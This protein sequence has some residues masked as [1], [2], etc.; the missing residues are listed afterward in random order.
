MTVSEYLKGKG[1]YT[2]GEDTEVFLADC[3]DQLYKEYFEKGDDKEDYPVVKLDT[4][5]FLNKVFASDE[6]LSEEDIFN[7]DTGLYYSTVE[8]I[9]KVAIDCE[10]KTPFQITSSYW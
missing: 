8:S 9:I 1:F 7:E 2:Y 3:E 10:W 6:K 5:E 4:F